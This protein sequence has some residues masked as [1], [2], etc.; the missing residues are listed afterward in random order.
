MPSGRKPLPEP[1]LSQIYF[2]TS[3]GHNVLTAMR[4]LGN[5][6]EVLAASP[7][8]SFNLGVKYI[9][10]W[11]SNAPWASL[12][13]GSL[14]CVQMAAHQGEKI[15]HSCY[16]YADRITVSLNRCKWYDDNKPLRAIQIK[17]YFNHDWLIIY[18]CI[19]KFEISP[20]SRYKIFDQQEKI[21]KHQVVF[22]VKRAPRLPRRGS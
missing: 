6:Q 13:C 10:P 1:T 3:L 7:N 19:E 15:L 21:I 17:R 4:Q 11:T 18:C 9:I 14:Q 22:I 8:V 16:T 12:P 20:I 5:R 2:V